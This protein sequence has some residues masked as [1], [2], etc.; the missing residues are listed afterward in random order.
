MKRIALLV[1]LGGCSKSAP[2]TSTE[3]IANEPNTNELTC[4]VVVTENPVFASFADKL[5][6]GCK[7]QPPSQELLR[8][9][10]DVASLDEIDRCFPGM[11]SLSREETEELTHLEALR[12]RIREYYAQHGA[13]PDGDIPLTPAVACCDQGRDDRMCEVDASQW[14][15]AGWD[16]LGFS[17]EEPH[18]YQYAYVGSAS[19]FE[20]TLVG[21]LDCDRTLSTYTLEGIVGDDGPQYTLTKPAMME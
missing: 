1:V 21:D 18:R 2:A 9:L 8:C 13:F 20:V 16:A 10:K 15:V 3:T 17:V 7:Q 4:E 5:L 14:A 19:E 11:N 6:E 12:H